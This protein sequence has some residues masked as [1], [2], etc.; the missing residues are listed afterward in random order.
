MIIKK[1]DDMHLHLRDG[2][3]LKLYAKESAKNFARAIVMPNTNPP[4]NT[5]ERVEKYINDIKSCTEGFTPL[6]IFKLQESHSN[7]QIKEF[8]NL[9]V[10]AAK[11]YPKGATTNSE[12][13]IDSI[14][15]LYPQFEAL[16]SNNLVL[17]IHGEDP[18]FSVFEREKE[19]LKHLIKI[20]KNFPKLRVVLEHIST[21]ESAKLI[22]EL[23]EN[24]V[25]TV[26]PQ[27]LLFTVDNLLGSGLKPNF[28]CKPILQKS[29]DRAE[30]QKT[31]LSGNHKFF[32]G[33]DSAPHKID[34]KLSSNGAAGIF[35]SPVAIP[36]LAEFFSKNNKIELL[37]PFTSKFG[38][39]FYGLEY[40][41]EEIEIVQEKWRVPE[42]ICGVM[43]MCAGEILNFKVL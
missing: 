39:D 3:D 9:G 17:S 32:L 30:I 16:Q 27:H 14:E 24:I 29:D 36:L 28:Y 40:N 33:T 42:K 11:L 25:A 21:K 35:S 43:P 7:S 37:E 15:A 8:K 18:N 34:K 12:D 26:T 10:F 38:A 22:Q 6:P 23:P 1:P 4:L 19:F 20:N 5:A 2:E 31:V 41:N 13:G